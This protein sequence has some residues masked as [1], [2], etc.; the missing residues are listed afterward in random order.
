MH[1]IT[2]FPLGNADCC[3][4][5]LDNGRKMLFDYAHCRNPEDDKDLR[6]DLFAALHENLAT[7]NRDY[8]D[9]TAFTHADDDHIKGAS[10][11]FY[12]EHANKYQGNGRIKIN[13]LWVP[14]AMIVEENLN[15]EAKIIRAE[16]RYRLKEGKRVRVFSRPDRLKDWLENEGIKLEHRKHLITDAGELVPGSNKL[17]DGVE[18]FVHSPFA[19]RMEDG[20]IDRNEDS[21]I[22]HATFNFNGQETR[23]M[24]IGDT[25]YEVLTEIVNITKYHKRE[26]RLAWD[27][28]DVPHHCSYLALSN[29]RGKDKTEPV[30]D[31]KWLFEQGAKG[32]ILVSPSKPI[33]KNDEDPQPPHRQAANYYKEVA[34]KISGDFAVTMEHPTETN[35]K[36]LVITIDNSG[37]TLKKLI[38]TGG[39]AGG[40][41]RPA[42]RAGRNE[43]VDGLSTITR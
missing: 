23:F 22:L 19:K 7:A 16:A 21:L 18:F 41:N 13:E 42:P 28:F 3:L 31:V 33:P 43:Y 4:I 14:A 30:P 2:F 24:L 25:T 26:T 11:F 1:K 39:A 5:D 27:I 17:S 38:I 29:E 40:G 8:F 15:G 36:P 35:P 34:Y 20:L 32:G 10:D 12:L 9:V 6:I 37:A